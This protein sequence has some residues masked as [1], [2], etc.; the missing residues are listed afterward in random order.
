MI[1]S[2]S[3]E[4]TFELAR[5][6]TAWLT[7]TRIQLNSVALRIDVGSS[8]SESN[9]S[10]VYFKDQNFHRAT[11]KAVIIAAQP[12]SARHLVEHLLDGARRAAWGNFNTVPVVVANVALRSAAPLAVLGLGYSQ[13]WWGSRYWAN[14]AVADWVTGD[15]RKK[16][17]RPTVLTFYGGNTAPPEELPNERIKLLQTPFGD[18]ENSI[19]DDLSRILRGSNFDFDRDVTAI[20][21]YRW[22]HSMFMP[23]P[24]LVFGNVHGARG[25]LDRTKSPRR[26]ACRPLGPI[27][28][29]GQHT[30]GTPSVESAIASGHR[31]AIEVLAR[32]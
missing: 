18:Y 13:A 10:V 32:L 1:C 31:T 14:F 21:L 19:R 20:S 30:E 27:S 11:A 23:T 8:P 29:A 25:R 28:F 15:Q 3:P 5:R 6:L 26:V 2:R 4:G 17:T 7:K 16:T 24:N 22:G 12:H 9:P